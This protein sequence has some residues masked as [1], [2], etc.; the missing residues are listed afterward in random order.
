MNVEEILSGN[1]TA[2]SSQNVESAGTVGHKVD[3]GRAT[4]V[5]PGLTSSAYVEG[6]RCEV[7]SSGRDELDRILRDDR[8]SVLNLCLR[9]F[10]FIQLIIDVIQ[11]PEQFCVDSHVCFVIVQIFCDSVATTV[12]NLITV[13]DVGKQFHCFCDNT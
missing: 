4:S 6:S 5:C 1:V 2:V 12:H 8:F 3:Q 13:G 7:F 9:Q 10:Y 11:T